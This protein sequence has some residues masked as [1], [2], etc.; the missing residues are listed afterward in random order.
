MSSLISYDLKCEVISSLCFKGGGN[1]T[2]EREK[3]ERGERLNETQNLQSLVRPMMFSNL[4][5]GI[6]MQAFDKFQ[7]QLELVN[8]RSLNTFLFLITRNLNISAIKQDSNAGSR[9]PAE[10]YSSCATSYSFS[11]LIWLNERAR[12]H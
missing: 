4:Q 1:N 12:S 5:L 8:I 11:Y 2:G 6:E 10:T 3:G 7:L 9:R